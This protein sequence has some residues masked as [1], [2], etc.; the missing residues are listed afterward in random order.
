MKPAFCALILLATP[1]LAPAWAAGG[2]GA[3]SQAVPASQ[4]QMAMTIYA[5]GIT[6]GKMDMD[7]VLRGADYHVVSHLNTSGVVN[8]FWQA[9]IQ[10]T[11]SGKVG[12]KGLSPELYDS[13]DTGHAGKKQEVSLTYESGNSPRLYADPTYSTTGF[14]VKPEDARATLDPLSAVM[15]IASGVGA[16]SGDPCALTAPVFDGRRRYD[17]EM[18]K[19]RDIDVKMDNGLYQGKAVQCD[20]RYRQIAGYRPR[21]LKSNE[22]FPAIHAWIASF[23]STV[24][25]RDYTLP[26]RVWA[27]TKYGMI[28]VLA[29]SIRVDGAAPKGVKP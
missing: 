15:F 13:F 27:D 25:G 6:L 2:S 19:A 28:A 12:A 8:A 21:V 24:T 18:T 4:L 16:G 5:G 14:E 3:Q 7:A 23:P 10:A 17:I 11:A 29:D 20:I 22:A 9:E 26:L 1:A